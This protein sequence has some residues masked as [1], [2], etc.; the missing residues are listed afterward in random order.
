MSGSLSLTRLGRVSVMAVLLG[1]LAVL[2]V[3]PLVMTLIASFSTQVPFSGGPPGQFTLDNYRNLFVPELATATWNTLI[4]AVGGT[5]MAVSIGATLAW[6]AARTDIPCKPLVHL[7]GLMPLFVSLVVASVTWS[8][9]G[10][11]RSGY[12]NIILRSLGMDWQ[13]DMR[14]LTGIT[15]LHGLYYVPYS[16]ILLFG[17]FSLI[18]PEMEQA[19]S[20][21]GASAAK[22]MR[23][24]TFPLVRPALLGAILL[25]FVAM[26]E[27]FPVP[28]ILGGPVGIETLSTRIFNLMT[29]VPGEP[30][31]AASVG[32]MLTA[33]V[34]ALVW[35]QRRLLQGRDF[36]TVTGKGMRAQMLPLGIFRWIALGIVL[37]YAFV[38]LG[39]PL[40]ALAIGALRQGMFIRD[41]AAL[42]DINSFS[43]QALKTTLAD[44]HVRQAVVNTLVTGLATA[45]FGTALYFILAYVVMRTKLPGRQMLEYLAMVPLALPALVMGIGVLWTWL[46]MPVPVYGTL[47]VLII[48]F[49]GRLLPQG[50]RA[51]GA[52]IGQIHDDLEHAAMISGATRPQAIYRIT[53]PLMRGAVFSSAFLTL[54]LATRELTSSLLLYTTNTRVLSVVIYE[55]YEQGLWSFVASIS[56]IYTVLLLVL[57]LVGRRWMRSTF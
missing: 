30:N 55:A 46:A 10:S 44:E 9:L 43:L 8:V 41:A 40:A 20:V 29:R 1:I 7:V 24:I 35:L 16:Y 15:I 56:L 11:G 21:H 54:V 25:S 47:L 19:A 53:L 5:V 37:L 27:E 26:A 48:A 57:T 14:S 3:S 28:A 6:L 12:L 31:Q 18:H 42:F 23:R 36:R 51:I 22:V 33:I 52:S 32:I 49:T 45:F 17:A 39:L 34:S 4:I 13:I 50:M 2:V 38:S